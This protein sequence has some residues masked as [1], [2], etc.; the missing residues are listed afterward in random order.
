MQLKLLGKF[1]SREDEDGAAEKHQDLMSDEFKVK[2]VDQPSHEHR[3]I[4]GALLLKNPQHQ[5][6]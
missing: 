6:A 5:A 1:I 4:S 3:D 2:F